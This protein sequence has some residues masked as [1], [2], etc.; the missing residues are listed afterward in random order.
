MI[1]NETK[2]NYLGSL[3]M[4]L[5]EM[6]CRNLGQST[7]NLLPLRGAS[8][9]GKNLI[10]NYTDPQDQRKIWI[11]NLFTP[12]PNNISRD[13]HIFNVAKRCII[14]HTEQSVE[15][16]R[17]AITLQPLIIDYA[18]EQDQRNGLLHTSARLGRVNCVR[19]ITENSN[20]TSFEN[21]MDERP[22]QIAAN[23][24]IRQIL[25]Q[26]DL[27]PGLQVGTGQNIPQL[28]PQAPIHPTHAGR[29][30]GAMH[31][32][33][34]Q[35]VVAGRGGGR[36]IIGIQMGALFGNNLGFATPPNFGRGAGR[37]I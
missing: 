7:E 14:N 32:I 31:P 6:I 8:K 33:N 27:R 30:R 3:D 34:P 10:D 23:E 21:V 29:G 22:N 15:V 35:P 2:P 13:R 24:E 4:G 11:K 16:L 1:E 18:D 25:I 36:G 19:L 17:Y 20:K 12:I 37:G 9:S 28:P 26:A 5:L